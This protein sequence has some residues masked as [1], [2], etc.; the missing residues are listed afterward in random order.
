[1]STNCLV[2]KLKGAVDNNTL[3]KLGEF[4]IYAAININFKGQSNAGIEIR[5][6]DGTITYNGVSSKQVTIIN[7]SNAILQAGALYFVKAPYSLTILQVSASDVGSIVD[8]DVILNSRKYSNSLILSELNNQHGTYDISKC[9]DS[10]SSIQN[11]ITISYLHDLR[12]NI[13]AFS[14][15]SANYLN[16]NGTLISGDIAEMLNGYS[17]RGINTVQVVPNGVITFGKTVLQKG[18]IHTFTYSGGEWSY[19]VA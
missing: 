10:L 2:T 16:I 12:G 1:M 19:T 6:I 11:E 13:S 15:L 18:K 5:T 4:T 8:Y 17:T 14:V 3:L 7:S 9:A